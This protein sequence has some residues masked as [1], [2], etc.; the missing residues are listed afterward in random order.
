L[1]QIHVKKRK[2]RPYLFYKKASFWLSLHIYHGRGNATSSDIAN[3]EITE[4]WAHPTRK[5]LSNSM[6][7]AS[8]YRTRESWARHFMI[9]CRAVGFSWCVFLVLCEVTCR[10]VNHTESGLAEF[11]ALSITK[12][13]W[14]QHLLAAY[15]SGCVFL[16]YSERVD[17]QGDPLEIQTININSFLITQST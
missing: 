9:H 13:I 7:R 10:C 16:Q 4:Q 17:V 5:E 2:L 3:A 15:K 6:N 14:I 11:N 1:R 12:H 8:V